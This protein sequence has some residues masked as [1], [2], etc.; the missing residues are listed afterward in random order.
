MSKLSFFLLASEEDGEQ[1]PFRKL[2]SFRG[3]KLL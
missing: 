3:S 2:W 1:K